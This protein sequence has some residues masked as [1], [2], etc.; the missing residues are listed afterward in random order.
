[1]TLPCRGKTGAAVSQHWL[2]SVN[3]EAQGILEPE[4]SGTDRPLAPALWLHYTFVMC[5]QLLETR[6]LPYNL[7]KTNLWDQL[8]TGFL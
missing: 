8:V 6:S 1:M 2:S 7:Q 3:V 5:P 4:G